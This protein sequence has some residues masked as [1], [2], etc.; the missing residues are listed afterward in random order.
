MIRAVIIGF[1]HMH[2][3]E[4]ALYIHQEPE[5]QLVACADIPA[6]IPEIQ[7]TR[8]T[9]GWNQENIRANFCQT[10]YED[11]RRMLDECR[12]DIAFLLCETYRKHEVVAEC[13]KRGIAVS[14]EKPIEVSF[15]EAKKIQQ[16]VENS[17]IEAVVNWP[18]TW[19]PYLHQMKAALDSGLIGDL[20]KIRFLIGN[21]GPVGRGA[22]HR[23]VS[24]KA[25]AMSDEAKSRMWWYRKACGGGALLDFICY[26]CMFSVWMMGKQA[27]AVSTVAV[28][29]TTKFADIYDNAGALLRFGDKL[30]VL[31]GTWATPSRAIPAGP[32]LFGSEGVLWC[33]KDAEAKGGVA[34]HACDIYGNDLAVPAFSLPDYRINIAAEYAHHKKTGD[35]MHESLTFP[36]NMRVMATLD[37]AVRSAESGKSEIPADTTGKAHA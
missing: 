16:S 11:Y 6:E 10:I 27:D 37:A 17:G 26:G 5:M 23:G 36:F 33:E 15:D 8:Y 35:S 22:M 14:I 20:L 21:T 29:G 30:A 18:L 12:P 2:V 3:N 19:R 1:A 7:N 28:N 4:V 25:E 13:A 34:V 31:E 32:T 24:E 9:R